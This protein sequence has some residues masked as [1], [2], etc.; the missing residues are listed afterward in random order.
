MPEFINLLSLLKV[1][2]FHSDTGEIV[3]DRQESQT[4]LLL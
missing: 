1:V 3:F 2:K 4:P